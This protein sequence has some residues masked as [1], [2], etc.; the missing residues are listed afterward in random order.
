ML[1]K[2]IVSFK[3]ISLI[4]FVLSIIE[5]GASAQRIP[6]PEEI[7]GF[8]VG[9]DYHLADY[10]QALEYLRALEKASP[11]IKL[12]EM[13]KTEMGKPMIYA[14]ISS[15]ENLARLEHYKE[16][17]RRLALAK[18]LTDEEARGLAA[19][20]RAVVYIEGGVHADE[21]APA[22]SQIQL[23]YDL[24]SS[25]DPETRIIRDNVIFLLVFVNPDGMQL[26]AE[27]YRPNVGTPFEVSPMP[28]RF[29]K[30][31]GQNINRDAYMGNIE[32]TRNI[33]RLVNREWYPVILYSH[34]Q[35]APFPARIWI[36]PAAEPTNPNLHPLQIRGKNLIGSAM[37]MAFD[38]E[39]K[40]GAI[41]RIVFD[42]WYPGYLD[43]FVDFFNVISIMTETALYKY[44]TPHFYTTNDFPESYRDFT[45]GAFYPNPWKG[46]WWRFKDAVDY[47]LTASKSA[48]HTAAVYREQLLYN[49]YQMGRDVAA[50][51]KKEPPYAWIITRNQWDPPVAARLLDW[52]SESGIE[53]YKAEEPFVSDGVSH[54]AGTWIIPMD[55]P[56]SLY[57]KALFE[58]Q[59]YPDLTKYP[60]LWQGIVS[61]QSTPDAYLP[62]YDMAGWTLPYQMGV[63]VRA[64][65]Q[66]LKVP[67]APLEDVV[68]PGGT[69]ERATYN[70]ISPRTNNSYIAVN[71][72]LKKG[73]TVQRARE[74]FTAG[75]KSYPPGTFVVVS[76]SVPGPF[77]EQL[78]TDLF[79]TIGGT[80]SL[81][82]ETFEI[83]TPRVALYNPWFGR[84]SEDGGWTQ[85]V[86][87]Q[88]EFPFENIHDAEIKAGDMEKRFE[89]LVIPS[90]S[91]DAIVNGHRPGTIHPKYVGGIT[92]AGIRNIRKFVGEGG[93]L[94]TLNS[95]CLFAIDEL[96]LPV[97]DAL[98][99]L[100]PPARGYGD[101]FTA[102]VAEFACPGSVLRMEFDPKHPVAFGMPAE[103]P[104]MF[105]NSPAF[106]IDS[107][108]SEK[109][110]VVIANYPGEN[111]LMS[112]YL[113]GGKHLQ[114]RAAVVDVPFGKG[115]VLLL[116]FGVK[117]RAQ[118]QGTFKLL[119]NS[120]YSVPP[121]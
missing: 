33:V 28:W 71:R 100:R 104:A 46:G 23:A 63:K 39:G 64:A 108:S 102:K 93:T 15:E 110:P 90:M 79:I 116:G 38:Q 44:A 72:I 21:C 24:I 92:D 85:L 13:G 109:A 12:F 118:P 18:G 103:A 96:D 3:A 48:L 40:Q 14:V 54:P 31:A 30:Y 35:T 7:I 43:N 84:G 10:S 89:V 82:E 65:Q 22:Q 81:V 83:K 67:M 60:A 76:G 41:S 111:L 26:L 50:R 5:G 87:D 53:V 105:I 34:H 119:F 97:S 94:V 49:K 70:L 66:H 16:I 17:S 27:W 25:E 52:L 112:G 95:G 8:K 32:E 4:V 78:A 45:V 101:D 73:G 106:N 113:K 6:T 117:Q 36:P 99:G 68:P 91:T 19:D 62:P 75:G 55:Q 61:P 56:F 51:F 42:F 1:K 47:S 58:E 120:L 74:A 69:V 80:E 57:V 20:G 88:H 86:L 29:H 77:M 2:M 107:S 121:R 115:R 114:K 11:M 59:S 9:E 98:Q 37:G